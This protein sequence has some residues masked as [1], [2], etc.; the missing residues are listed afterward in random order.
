MLQHLVSERRAFADGIAEM[1]D[2]GQFKVGR[3][4]GRHTARRRRP[5]RRDEDQDCLSAG[6]HCAGLSDV[7]RLTCLDSW[8]SRQYA[9]SRSP[10]ALVRLCGWKSVAMVM[11]Y[12]HV[13]V[14]ELAPSIDQLHP[15]ETW[16][17]TALESPKAHE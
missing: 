1:L 14:E 5:F 15:G 2:D 13:T 11:R 9:Q 12:A 8:T 3:L 10:A 16:R 4:A 6:C 17:R 7:T